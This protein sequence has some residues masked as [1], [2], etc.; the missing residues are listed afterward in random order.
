LAAGFR[1]S[2]D[3]IHPSQLRLLMMMHGG[4][5]SPSDLADQMEVSLP[6]IS[7]SL[8]GLERRGWIE[9]APDPTDRRRVLLVM[10]ETG[11]AQ[12]RTSF[13]AGIAQLE[14]A[15]SSA[16]DEELDSIDAGLASLQA[17]FARFMPEHHFKGRHD[18]RP[19]KGSD[20]NR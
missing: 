16:S 2:G 10:T 7:K 4:A 8:D 3:G 6:T 19:E 11:R 18:R 15:L 20:Q 14:I 9:R 12:M 13:D 17:V 1:E 5:V